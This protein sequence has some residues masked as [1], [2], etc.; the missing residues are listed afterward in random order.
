MSSAS[1]LKQPCRARF[2]RSSRSDQVQEALMQSGFEGYEY[3]SEF[4]RKYVA[5]PV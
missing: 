5:Q 3:Q 4:A 1:L 2:T